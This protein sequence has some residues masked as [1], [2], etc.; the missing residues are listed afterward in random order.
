MDLFVVG[1]TVNRLM[2]VPTI[3]A[4]E[5]GVLLERRT[6]HSRRSFWPDEILFLFRNA[7]LNRKR[8]GNSLRTMRT[9]DRRKQ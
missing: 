8:F 5:I 4:E 6:W 2:R 9:Q 7:G 1:Q 3:V